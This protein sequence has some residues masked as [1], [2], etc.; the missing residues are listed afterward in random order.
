MEGGVH[1]APWYDRNPTKLKLEKVGWSYDA[2]GNLINDGSMS[3]GYE[4]LNRLLAQGSITNTYNG[5]GVLIIQ[6]TGSGTITYTQDL[7]SPLSQIL[8]DG[9][10][11]YIY[12]SQRLLGVA[13]ATETWYSTD[14]LGSLRQ[15][16]DAVGD[17][18]GARS[19]KG[20]RS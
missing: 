15:T 1:S 5:D 12:G 20:L 17:V 13:G 16:L 3:Y 8:N 6:A 14:A 7:V 11:N 9:S 10:A 2:A 19:A 18:C 4:P